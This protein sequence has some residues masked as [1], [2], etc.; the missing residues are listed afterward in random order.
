MKREGKAPRRPAAGPGAKKTASGKL[1]AASRGKAVVVPDQGG[2]PRRDAPRPE[3]EELFGSVL[4]AARLRSD[5]SVAQIGK[6]LK[7]SV[8]TVEALERSALDDL[9]PEVFVRGFIKSFARLV[10]IPDTEPIARLDQML[11]SRR[12][13]Q[14]SATGFALAPNGDLV[15]VDSLLNDEDALAPRRGVGLAIFV[16]IVLVIA[17]ITVSYLLRQPPAPGEGLSLSD[18]DPTS[19]S[20]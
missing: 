12:R 3:A 1:D 14:E 11:A 2:T 13:E 10:N 15:S 17:T 8:F 5:L 9:P 4:K 19:E 18:P 7:L 20:V 6:S 16:V